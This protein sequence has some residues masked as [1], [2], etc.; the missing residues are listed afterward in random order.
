MGEGRQ[1]RDIAVRL[2]I[3]EFTVKRHVHNILGKLD[4][5]SRAAAAR[6]HGSACAIGAHRDQWSTDRRSE[7]IGVG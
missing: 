6:L 7:R 5:P 3:S 1:N 2:G 4:V